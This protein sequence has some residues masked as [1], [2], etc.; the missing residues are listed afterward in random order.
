MGGRH[1][2]WRGPCIL[3][4]ILRY[5]SSPSAELSLR[6]AFAIFSSVLAL[7][8]GGAMG[9]RTNDDAAASSVDAIVEPATPRPSPP[10]PVVTPS[11]TECPVV[12]TVCS[13]EYDPVFCSADGHGGMQL[14]RPVM[15]W[16]TNAC[17]G[18]LALAREACK[19]KLAPSRLERVQ[20]VPDASNG[21]CPAKR[22]MCAAEFAPS[23]CAAASYGDQALNGEQAPRASGSN[24]C[25]ARDK[26]QEEACRLNLDPKKLGGITCEPDKLGGECPVED[27]VCADTATA[28]ATTCTAARGGGIDLATSLQ[29]KGASPCAAKLALAR[30][31]C[32]SGLKPSGLDEI[33]CKSDK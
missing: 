28:Q 4:I 2:L 15:A 23:V 7:V 1:F 5:P 8:A 29:A 13:T 22:G 18:R 19:A 20:C 30:A 6:R 31:A 33:V 10:L 11:A 21:N 14:R 27:V 17:Q 9:C 24:A 32:Q 12:E 16:G 3:S 26:L 25:V